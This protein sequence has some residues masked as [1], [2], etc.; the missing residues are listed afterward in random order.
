MVLGSTQYVQAAKIDVEFVLARKAH[1]KARRSQGKGWGRISS[2]AAS[3]GGR[4]GPAMEVDNLENPQQK[5]NPGRTGAAHSTI[6]SEFRGTR[7]GFKE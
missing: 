7:R 1:T 2:I 6:N 4:E 3:Y 5:E